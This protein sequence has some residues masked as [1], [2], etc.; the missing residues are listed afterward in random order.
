MKTK[1]FF[2]Y[3]FLYIFHSSYSLLSQ[4]CQELLPDKL[5]VVGG[6]LSCFAAMGKIGDKGILVRFG[7]VEE[8]SIPR[9]QQ[10]K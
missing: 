1:V 2:L 8:T 9:E 10:P 3:S 5:A 7:F 4:S 6:R